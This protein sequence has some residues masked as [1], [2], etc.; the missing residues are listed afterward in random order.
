MYLNI[1][2]HRVINQRGR[3]VWHNIQ[4]SPTLSYLTLYLRWKFMTPTR[5]S[6]SV[7]LEWAVGLEVSSVR[8]D[9]TSA[10]ECL[11]A[12]PQNCETR[13]AIRST[14]SNFGVATHHS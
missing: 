10:K 1:Y 2:T 11:S 8:W 9:G 7:R 4:F 14:A 6:C 3:G 12:L 5:R 13:S